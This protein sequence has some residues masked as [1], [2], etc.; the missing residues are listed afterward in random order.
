MD[1]IIVIPECFKELI[2]DTGGVDIVLEMVG[3]EVFK[4]GLDVLNPFGR[5]VVTG[6]ASLD[7]KKWNPLSWIKIWR[8]IPRVDVGKL[9]KKSIAV[10]SSHVGYLLEE[11]PDEMDIILS[12]LKDFVK[13]HDIKPVIGKIFPFD[14]ASEAHRYIE[15]RK[16]FGKV[17]LRMSA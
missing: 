3:G 9:A 5:I 4:K 15:S 2:K 6:F 12:D 8:D 1:I 17:L 10:M 11:E 16:S 7:L 13:K 14:E